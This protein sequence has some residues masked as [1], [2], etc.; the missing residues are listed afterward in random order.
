MSYG[1]QFYSYTSID[2]TAHRLASGCEHLAA[3]AIVPK[4]VIAERQINRTLLKADILQKLLILQRP[5]EWQ[6]FIAGYGCGHINR[7]GRV[8]RPLLHPLPFFL[9]ELYPCMCYGA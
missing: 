1:L 2:I 3:V 7:Q 5:T 6:I 4:I 8:A 9:Y